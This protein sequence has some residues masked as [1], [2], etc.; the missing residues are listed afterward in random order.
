MS[1]TFKPLSEEAKLP[2]SAED[3]F[4]EMDLP[5]EFTEDD[6]F[7][8]QSLEYFMTHDWDDD[9]EWY[10]P[11]EKNWYSPNEKRLLDHVRKRILENENL[12]RRVVDSFTREDLAVAIEIYWLKHLYI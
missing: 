9:I 8:W 4:A 3:I 10:A 6:G 5:D 1:K 2:P 11:N 12:P 7:T